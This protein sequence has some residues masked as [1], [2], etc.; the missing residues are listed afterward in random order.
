MNSETFLYP[1]RI[2]ISDY[3][4]KIVEGRIPELNFSSR[5]DPPLLRKYGKSGNRTRASGSV[6]RNSD[7]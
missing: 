3:I 2:E 5:P 7:H 1:I 4:E 6:A